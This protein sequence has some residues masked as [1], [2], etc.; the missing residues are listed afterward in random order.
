MTKADGSEALSVFS[1][2]FEEDHP[3]GYYTRGEGYNH[4][5]SLTVAD[6][7]GVLR[8]VMEDMYSLDVEEFEW[9]LNLR[10]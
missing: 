9:E 4:S 1:A 8:V 10:S 5:W 7:V 6:G 2:W 3:S